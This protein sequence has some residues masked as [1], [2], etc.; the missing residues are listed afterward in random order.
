MIRLNAAIRW[1]YRLILLAGIAAGH[2]TAGIKLNPRTIMT[3][4]LDGVQ[5]ADDSKRGR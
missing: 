4:E 1:L 3:I 2:T 5:R